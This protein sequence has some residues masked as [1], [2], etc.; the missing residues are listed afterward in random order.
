MNQAKKTAAALLSA[1]AFAHEHE[2]ADDAIRAYGVELSESGGIDVIGEELS[3]LLAGRTNEGMQREALALGFLAGRV[4]RVPR[5]ERPRDPTAF[6]MNSDLV[7][8][9]AEGESVLRLPWFE[10]EL[11]VGRQLP[12][13]SEM[14]THIRNLAVETYSNALKGE[15]G[16]FRFISYGHS[17]SVDAVPVRSDGGSYDAVLAVATPT[18]THVLAREGYE[19]TAA[20]L[21]QS[22]TLA[23]GRA[24]AH[25][26]ASRPADE[27]RERRAAINARGAAARMSMNAHDLRTSDGATKAKPALTDREREVLQLASH[28]MTLKESAQ[29]LALSVATVKTHHHNAYAKLGTSDKAAAVACALRQGLIH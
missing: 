12:D 29:H 16:R 8:E 5:M 6:F 18:P 4:A 11:F 3:G 19:R 20:R 24:E 2:G 28:G 10:D 13:I 15:R 26:L 9:D 17:F 22:A 27:D 25:R 21:E 23:E 7:V 1:L 14:P